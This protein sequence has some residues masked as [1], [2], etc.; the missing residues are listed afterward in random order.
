MADVR[1]AMRWAMD[2]RFRSAATIATSCGRALSTVVHQLQ[3]M[4]KRGEVESRR[5]LGFA[6]PRKKLWRLVR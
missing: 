4:E 5:G 6:H 1:G 3:E 2:G